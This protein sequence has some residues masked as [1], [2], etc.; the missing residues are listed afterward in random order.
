MV[1]SKFLIDGGSG[2]VGGE[3]YPL[4]HMHMV[5]QSAELS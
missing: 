4:R 5:G 1:N 2:R 3:R